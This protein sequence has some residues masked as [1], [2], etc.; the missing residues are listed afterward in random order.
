MVNRK[1][2]KAVLLYKSYDEDYHEKVF[3]YV[4]I[5]AA[6]E[7]ILPYKDMSLVYQNSA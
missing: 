7:Q 5:F 6:Y 2:S 4:C 3:N 1:L